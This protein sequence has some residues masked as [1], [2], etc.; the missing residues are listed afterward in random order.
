MNGGKAAA[1]TTKVACETTKDTSKI[2]INS[3]RQLQAKFKHA[4]D[5]GVTGNYS[6]SNAVNFCSAINQHINQAGIHVINGTYRKNAVIHH[7]NPHTGL[8]V[9]SSPSGEFIS[10]WT[11]NPQ[12]M[13]NV[14]KHGGL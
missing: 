13:Q 1:A 12:Q 8:N 4:V 9:I 7:L 6:K 3:G 5:F 10:G 11:L 14:L 2:L